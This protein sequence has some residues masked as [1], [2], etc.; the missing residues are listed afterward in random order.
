MSRRIAVAAN[1]QTGGITAALRAMLPDDTVNP[2]W[3]VGDLELLR[4]EVEGADI[5]VSALTEAA[6]AA[7]V[8]VFPELRVI[9]IP[10]L[11]F[12]AFHP[13][14]IHVAHPHGGPLT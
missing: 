4:D 13:D 14:V 10:N 8:R 7:M 5:W 12:S 3:A 1:C 9:A 11:F 6:T 2:C